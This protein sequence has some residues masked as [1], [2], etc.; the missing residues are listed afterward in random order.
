MK[1]WDA[2]RSKRRLWVAVFGV[3][4]AAATATGVAFATGLAGGGHSRAMSTIRY[5]AP[6]PAAKDD[7]GKRDPDA[8]AANLTPGPLGEHG[9]EVSARDF[10]FFHQRAY[11]SRVVPAGALARA[12]RQ[13]LALSHSATGDQ[14]T[15]TSTSWTALGPNPISVLGAD[16]NW[17]SGSFAGATPF[18]GRVSAVAPAPGNAT[19]IYVGAANGGVWKSTTAGVSWTSVWPTTMASFSIGSIA[20][21]PNNASDVWVGTGEANG[22]GDAYFGNGLYHS[23]NGGTTWTRVDTSHQFQGCFVSSLALVPSGTSTPT[24]NAAVLEFPGVS[25]P[26]C[27]SSK[28]GIWHITNANTSTPTLTHESMPTSKPQCSNGTSA[29][30]CQAPNNFT[31]VASSPN[32]IFASG[33]LEGVWRSTNGGASWTQIVTATGYYREAVSAYNASTVYLA[34]SDGSGNWGGLYKITNAGSSS[35]AITAL[36]G[37]AATDSPCTYPS[38]GNGICWYALTVAADPKNANYVFV[39]GTRLYR[40]TT[41]ESNAGTNIGYGGGVGNIHVDQHA[42]VFDNAGNLWE[43]DDGGVAELPGGYVVGGVHNFVDRDGAGTSALGITEFNGWLTGSYTGTSTTDRLLGGTQDN[44]TVRY[45]HATGLNWREDHGG[46]GGA[47]AYIN[48]LTYFASYFGTAVYRTTDGGNCGSASCPA[49][50]Q[51]FSS[52]DPAEFYAPLEQDPGNPTT[53]YRGTDAIYRTTTATAASPSWTMISPHW[54]PSG[55]TAPVTAIGVQKAA[56]PAYLY[57]GVDATCGSSGCS[58]APKLEYTHNATAATPTWSVGSGLPGRYITDI[59]VNPA[60]PANAILTESGFN[61][62][63]SATSGHVFKTTNGGA[64]WVNISGNLPNV[65]VNA[66]AVDPANAAKIFLGTDTGVFSTTTGTSSPPTWANLNGSTLP[67]TVVMD[68]ILQNGQLIAATH[69]RGVWVA[70]EP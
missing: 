42:T 41:S 69:G 65:P 19:V 64:S 67:G 70:P 52:S 51:V 47:S 35:Q 45:A 10:W 21:N 6:R 53:L 20:V 31:S 60:N 17:N 49:Y 23:T 32:T 5:V 13:T 43:G 61:G 3:A 48:T 14:A 62:S 27:S 24:V 63:T 38:A 55:S 29:V 54:S 18:A 28:R 33:Y 57:A 58:A 56:S 68:L 4:A 11:P 15:T 39:G 16:A 59:W 8:G 1:I 2:R 46:D 25:N 22:S 34:L 50:S 26:A 7:D 40:F 36:N 30:P 37:A 66:I 12:M 9:N 44:G